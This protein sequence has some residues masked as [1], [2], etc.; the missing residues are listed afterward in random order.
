MLLSHLKEA[1]KSSD[2]GLAMSKIVSYLEKKV[3][4]M[5]KLTTEK[6]KNSTDQGTGVRYVFDG[7]VLCVRFN[8]V[9]GKSSEIVSIDIW[10]GS[11]RDPNFHIT[12]K[13]QS[14]AK[15]LPALARAISKPKIGVV[16][17]PETVTEARKGSHPKHPDAVYD[18]ELSDNT[19]A[20]FTTD[21]GEQYYVRRALLP[22]NHPNKKPGLNEAKKG[23]YTAS[24]AIAD[25]I[26]K[27]EAGR[28]FNRSEFV[29]NYH[30]E[31][32][33]AYDEWVE[34]N[35]E[36][37]TISGKRI[38]LPKGTKVKNSSK[39]SDEGNGSVTV[40]KGGSD[41]EYDVHVPETDRVSFSDSIGHLESL[42]QG[43]I[44]GSFNAL[45][46][47]GKGGTGKTQTVEDVLAANGLTDGK[48]YFKITGS[49]SPIGMYTTLYKYRDDIILFD[50]ADGA[51]DSQDGRNIIKAATDTKKI[52]KLA[53]QKKS[54]G[55]FDPDSDAEQS[56]ADAR[57]ARADAADS[58]DAGDEG[59]DDDD[60]RVPKHFNF[61]GQI[62][63][64]SNLPLNKL[65]PDGALRTRAFIIAIDPTPDE[66]IQRMEEIVFSIKLEGSG[67][68]S[69]SQRT[70]VLDVIKASRRKSDASLRTLVRALNLAASGVQNWQKL[71]RLYA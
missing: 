19:T 18:P 56:K 70:E 15:S 51:L 63:F 69:D 71:V 14:L 49:A 17:V 38:S 10:T 54:A 61:T 45:F 66:M 44:R 65:D 16:T 21:D 13:G 27:L 48:G 52:R 50:D 37:L 60:D 53:W 40:S 43:L 28:S 42:T 58:E 24:S 6:F 33:H 35:K 62:I 23:E 47:A 55:M 25:M 29:M 31:N 4:K 8:W 46:V 41:E 34:E 64:I 68:L 32:A 5:T 1:V 22:D 36:K 57:K 67:K 30:P 26:E 11:S 2:Q 9:G 39:A 3:G 59:L 7:S 20:G 12:W